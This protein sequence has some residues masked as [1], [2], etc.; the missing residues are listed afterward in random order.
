[1][2]KVII[3]NP[4]ASGSYLYEELRRYGIYTIALYTM[5]FDELPDYVREDSSVFDKQVYLKTLD[6]TE[7]INI[8]REE[9]AS[10]I[11]NGFEHATSFT[12]ALNAKLLP[13]FAN[14][15]A[16]SMLRQN[17]YLQT[18]ALKKQHIPYIK[19]LKIN[20]D[21][22]CILEIEQA[23]GYP[24]FMKPIDG[25]ASIGAY[26]V[27]N[28]QELVDTINLIKSTKNNLVSFNEYIV[29][30]VIVGEEIVVDSFSYN[31]QHYISVVARYGKS[32]INNVPVYRYCEL[33]EDQVSWQE[34]VQYTKS[35]LDVINLRNGFAH[36]ELF[37]LAD[38][39]FRLIEINPR[40]SGGK[41]IINKIATA[42]KLK[43]QV[44]IFNDVISNQ[45]ASSNTVPALAIYAKAVFI[46][47]FADTAI[48]DP[49]I[50][51]HQIKSLI[52]YKLLAKIGDTR[53][54]GTL[55]VTHCS[56]I[57]LLSNISKEQLEKDTKTLFELEE[58]DE[59]I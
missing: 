16:T 26:K 25:S 45:K 57:I 52:D 4:Y 22:E 3:V 17:K 37:R 29:Q 38:G 6:L 31:G 53:K 39:S 30:E 54:S 9:G 55:D 10:Y 19:Q 5:P 34:A 40:I 14:D 1:M 7:A 36:T 27:S 58:L 51:S 49:S 18:E 15:C 43:N 28:Q 32:I 48:K 12:D 50:D 33:I 35:C 8:I 2:K 13:M 44:D 24:C 41:G 23:I 11:I 59:L 47:K 21:Q 42:C 56:M 20:I 46:F